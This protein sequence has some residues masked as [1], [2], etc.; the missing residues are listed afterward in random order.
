MLTSSEAEY[1]RHKKPRSTTVHRKSYDLWMV[2]ALGR[3]RGWVEYHHVVSASLLIPVL[4]FQWQV[5]NPKYGPES[6]MTS[7]KD[8]RTVPHHTSHPLP[9]C[10][11]QILYLVNM[12]GGS[13][14]IVASV[15][16]FCTINVGLIPAGGHT[17]IY[18]CYPSQGYRKP[19]RGFL[20]SIDL[21]DYAVWIRH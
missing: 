4:K 15:W 2:E 13:R 7:S 17:V 20:S 5:V 3:R 1:A 12:N 18:N 19:A 6:S 8:T 9:S 14:G 10:N 21:S 11:I 16:C